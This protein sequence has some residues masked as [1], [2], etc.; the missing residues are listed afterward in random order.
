MLSG[1]KVLL[2]I[3]YLA[4][5]QNVR[6]HSMKRN[7]NTKVLVIG[8]DG[9]TFKL[10]KPWVDEGKLPV[11]GRMLKEGSHGI[12]RSVIPP[13]SPTAWA[14]F[15]TGKNAGK[16]SIFAFG[17]LIDEEK[18]VEV[19]RLI[20]FS[21]VKEPTLWRILSDSGVKV[22]VVNI[23]LTYPPEEVNGFLI[24]CFFTPPSADVYTYPP[25][26]KDLLKDYRIDIEFEDS[27]YFLPEKGINT[28][29]VLKEQYIITKNRVKNS[30]MLI[31]KFNPDFFAINFKGVDNLQHLFWHEKGIILE[32]LQ[33]VEGYILEL[34]ETMKPDYTLIMSDHGFHPRGEKYFHLNSWLEN[35]R[36]LIRNQSLVG[37]SSTGFYSLGVKIVKRFSK[38]KSL[39]PEKLKRWVITEQIGIQI[40][41]ASSFAY[42]TR[43]GIYLNRGLIESEREDFEKFKDELIVKLNGIKDQETG[44]KIFQEVLKRE[45]IYKGGYIQYIPDIIFL[46]DEKYKINP[47]LY[48]EIIAPRLD[49][50]YQTGSHGADQNGILII[51]GKDIKR[52]EIENANIIDLAPTILYMI[53]VPI[54]DD[55]DGR[56]LTE[57]FEHEGHRKAEYKKYLQKKGKEVQWSKEEEGAIR[58]R[59]KALGYID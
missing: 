21:D 15:Y 58:D 7:S 18:K 37:K 44:Q 35:E 13:L 51:N 33:T 1:P 14:T 49:S 27:G 24:S 9:G 55:M 26:L 4:N 39:I 31:G 41:F 3:S 19:D 32:F 30:K 25:E 40:D 47:V 48:D 57:I 46:Q 20:N 29:K 2:I 28:E 50:S 54:S 11:L 52:Q 59:L 42:S 16:T 45:D 43:W 23:P 5:N 56:V 12:L 34:K 53:G 38:V 8:L 17:N 10:I 36:V 6:K 22:G